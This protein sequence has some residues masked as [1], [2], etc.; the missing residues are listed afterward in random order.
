MRALLFAAVLMLTALPV[1]AQRGAGN[2]GGMRFRE[3]DINR[4][5]VITRNEW[6]GSAQSFDVHDWNGDDRL[7]GEEVRTGNRRF[8]TQPPEQDFDPDDA[9]GF[10]NWT[11]AGF[12][13]LDHN[14]DGRINA[15]EWHYG[16]EVF[17]RVDQNRNGALERAEFLATDVDDDREDRF[18][19]LDANGNNTIE[20]N[21][22]HGSA[23]S[24]NALDRNRN[25]VLTRLEVSGQAAPQPQPRDQFASLDVN[26]NNVI[27]ADEWHWSR[28]SFE[29][30]DTNRDG[31]LTRQELTVAEA[32]SLPTAGAGQAQGQGQGQYS[33]GTGAGQSF[34]VDAT[35][36]WTDTGI[37]LRPGDNVVFTATGIVRMS[38]D[39]GDTASPTG[40]VRGRLA[41]DS[42]VPAES[43]GGLI[44]RVGNTSPIFVGARRT[45][46]APVA[47]RLYL[48]VNDDHLPD[49]SGQFRVNISVN[50]R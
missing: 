14:R 31:V 27:S 43:A 24:F 3:M 49:N 26:R 29:M 1:S 30:Q 8:E 40:S 42:P 32:N 50:A 46:R 45:Y 37:D 48:S 10:T 5:G 47:G 41:A 36:R 39:Q 17:Y 18:E 4:D 33:V 9:D 12:R 23:A 35:Q 44:A 19:Y 6:R 15:N 21:E 28:R 16:T 11:E 34:V 25:G 22:W 20:R 13:S 7:S 2:Q 38:D